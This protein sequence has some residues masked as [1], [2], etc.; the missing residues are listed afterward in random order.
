MSAGRRETR[1]VTDK[2][3]RRIGVIPLPVRRLHVELTNRCNFSC[4]FCPD[5]HMQ[6]PRGAMAL[7]MAE[8]ILSHAGSQGLARQ[9]H[10]HVMGDP[11]LYPDLP[12]AVRYARASGLEAWITTNGALLT[13][14]LLSALEEAG[15]SHLTIS[16]QT[17]NAETFS[18]RGSRR[19]SFEEYRDRLV[20]TARA[21][22]AGDGGMGLTLC[23]LT[24]PLR[25]FRAPNA[26]QMPLA[27]SGKTLR[28][29]M[30]RW[31]EWIFD[32][33][34]QGAAVF[35]VV[36]RTRKVG[37]LKEGRV[38]LSSRL[39]FQVRAV[40]NWAAHFSGHVTQARF[41]FCPGLVENLGV[42]WNG[43]YVFCCTDYDGRT[44]MAN[45]AH[46]TLTE[47]LALPAVQGVAQGFQRYRVTHPYCRQCLGDSHPAAAVFR[48][49][50]S[51]L[52]F[53]I[54]RRL[55]DRRAAAREAV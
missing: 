54:Y 28:E 33:T 23:F 3:S 30:G 50:G 20:H 5:Q 47:Y 35:D 6:R 40:G 27:E 52:Y 17:P 32:G 8:R 1:A 36:A 19:L 37:I 21:F 39:D 49:I 41:G 18:L 38:P 7:S 31:A 53:K 12:Q 34:G 11:L 51:V 25:R 29:Q 44:V 4:E 16:L 15:L 42:L 43:D 46:I 24:N 2:G 13:P 22:L 10:F 48:Q 55:A 14:D 45:A 9:A 26:P